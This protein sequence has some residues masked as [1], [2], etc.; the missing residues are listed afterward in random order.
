VW[1][2]GHGATYYRLENTRRKSAVVCRAGKQTF[3][4]VWNT[5]VGACHT[6]NAEAVEQTPHRLCK[7]FAIHR[8][9]CGHTPLIYAERQEFLSN[10]HFR[11]DV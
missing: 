2:C 6:R 4:R 7:S 11:L 3:R 8:N 1:R 5:T 10:N 9:P